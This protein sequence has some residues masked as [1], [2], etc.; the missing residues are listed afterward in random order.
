MKKTIVLHVLWSGRAGGAER[1]VRDIVTYSDNTKFEHIVC[2]LSSGGIIAD[3]IKQVGGKVLILGMKSG[4]DILAGLKF[5]GLLKSENVNIVNV[6]MRSYFIIMLLCVF[7]GKVIRIYF[8]H[9]GN[10]ISNHPKKEAVFYRIFGPS[11]K[12]ILANS[13]YV[14]SQVL[15]VSRLPEEKVKTFYIGIDLAPYSITINKEEIKKEFRIPLSNK[16]VGIVGRL[17]VAKGIDDFVR[18]A[19]EIQK[20]RNDICFVIVGDGEKRQ[21]L[22]KLAKSLSV[23][24][25]F[26]GER[27]DIPKLLKLFDVFLFTSKW[28]AFGIVLLEAMASRV[29]VIGFN[30]PGA[31][32]IISK[33]GGIMVEGRNHQQ[34]AECVVEVLDSYEKCHKLAN[35]GYENVS[36]NFNIKNTMLKLELFYES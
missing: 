1:F 33:G 9:G 13:D 2:F 20:R 6:H 29:P 11:F 28:E 36:K 35:D 26:L 19:V 32:E 3:Q 7:G 12:V 25:I 14:R 17:V 31:N 34:A 15:K 8:E 10:L 22:E 30:I 16:V 24:I 27:K 23:N 21:N 5:I 18:I 4:F